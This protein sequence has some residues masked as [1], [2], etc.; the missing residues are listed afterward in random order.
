MRLLPALA[1]CAFAVAAG[2]DEDV[3]VMPVQNG[4]TVTG[5]HPHD[6]AHTFEAR[7]P[8]GARLRVRMRPPSDG[9]YVDGPAGFFWNGRVTDGTAELRGRCSVSG[10]Y[11][12]HVMHYWSGRPGPYELRIAW[13]SPTSF[14][15]PGLLVDAE[16]RATFTL[17]AD[18]G[19]TVACSV[20]SYDA[21]ATQTVARVLGPQGTDLVPAGADAK[22]FV[23]PFTGD[24]VVVIEG[25]AGD[26]CRG[27]ARVRPPARRP[28]HLSTIG[29]P[30]VRADA[31]EIVGAQGGVLAVP[32]G[33][34]A[35]ARFEIPADALSE[36]C[37]VALVE[38]ALPTDALGTL[39]PA[40]PALSILNRSAATRADVGNL[41]DLLLPFDP[42]VT[43]GTPRV[44]AGLGAAS[45]V[46]G[47]QVEGSLV[48]IP[49]DDPT[50]DRVYQ[51]FGTVP[52]PAPLPLAA[53]APL[54]RL[55]ASVDTRAGVV[56]IGIPGD[57][58]LGEDT[59]AVRV[60]DPLAGGD[61]TLRPPSAQPGDG[62][63]RAVSLSRDGSALAVG[64][65]RAETVFVYV[66]AGGA[67]TLDARID[68]PEPGN[69][70]SFGHAV[71]VDG[72]T[73]FVGAPSR[74]RYF[75]GYED[76]ALFVFDRGPGG[77]SPNTQVDRYGSAEGNLGAS[78]A[79]DGDVA[80][81]GAPGQWYQLDPPRQ[82]TSRHG[83]V[84]LVLRRANGEWF[85]VGKFGDRRPSF[86]VTG[87]G[88]S[89][90]V[91]GTT[92]I[93]GGWGTCSDDPANSCSD[94]ASALV[95]DADEQGY[96]SQSTFSAGTDGDDFGASV[97]IADGTA[98]VGS[99]LADLGGSFE[100]GRAT[101]FIREP[102]GAWIAR[103]SIRPDAPAGGERLG[104]AVAL[105]GAT[106]VVG[107]P[108]TDRD[109]GGVTSVDLSP[110]K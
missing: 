9:L 15:A 71:A 1:V 61:V 96:F 16:G 51:V 107:A 52:A 54:D 110:L 27:V 64:T 47:F 98:V 42:Q 45:E 93:A 49:V 4:D 43:G 63:G 74:R 60:I 53:G 106:L 68:S 58:A 12:A 65:E 55:G 7:C 36:R 18:A 8:A 85:R 33:L 39:R 97:A 104:A 5:R 81:V 48:R 11:G 41:G 25:T 66:R 46:S 91:D 28:R 83:G 77:W 3:L 69:T 94:F 82:D 95:L 90:A 17:S 75:G 31:L 26:R 101:V 13:R 35:G 84:V 100:S 87:L 57:D 50:G 88:R 19:A 14:R 2:A 56:A 70:M 44:F 62:F 23:A 92:V 86:Y 38:A 103:R 21:G 109:A 6:D 108:G 29:S 89:V 79:I 20:T 73:L 32:D 102:S 72:G 40:G 99:P 59:G 80:V 24:Y 30:L 105:D 10:V 34:A 37:Q 76:G 78:V 22:T 67:W